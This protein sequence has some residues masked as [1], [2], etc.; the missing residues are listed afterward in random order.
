M[1]LLIPR[2]NTASNAPVS[3]KG[4]A[5]T[6]ASGTPQRSYSADRMRYTMMSAKPKANTL[7]L[8]VRFSWKACAVQAMS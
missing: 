5:S 3:A 8:P 4:T 7:A 6:T 2:R 1:S